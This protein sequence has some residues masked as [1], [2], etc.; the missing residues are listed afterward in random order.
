MV[1]I[2]EL[3]DNDYIEWFEFAPVKD[4]FLTR[5]I[6]PKSTKETQTGIVLSVQE[7]RVEDR[8]KMAEVLSVGPECKF[9]V[10]EILFLQ[11]NSGYELENITKPADAEFQYLLLHTDAILGKLCKDVRKA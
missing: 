9:K 3:R 5:T 4:Y 7:S 11:K 1:D 8:P 2:N 6:P 10:G